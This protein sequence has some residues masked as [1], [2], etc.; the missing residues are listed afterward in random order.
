[1]SSSVRAR[2]TTDK[3]HI[4]ERL[5]SGEAQDFRLSRDPH[6]RAATCVYLQLPLACLQL[7]VLAHILFL[8]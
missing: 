5:E 2:G 6:A 3:P 1:M 8:R 4:V 7:H